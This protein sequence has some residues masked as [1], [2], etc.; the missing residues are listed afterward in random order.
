MTK[1]DKLMNKFMERPPR[2]DLTYQE[3]EKLLVN[4]DYNK[5]EGGGSRVNFTEMT[6]RSRFPFTNLIRETF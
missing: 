6:A 3:L 5:I 4:M 2:K 1:K